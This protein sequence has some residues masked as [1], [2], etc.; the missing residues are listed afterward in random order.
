MEKLV[1][2]CNWVCVALIS[3]SIVLLASLLLGYHYAGWEPMALI[4]FTVVYSIA[5]I[6][7]SIADIVLVIINRIFFEG[8]EDVK[9]DCD[10]LSV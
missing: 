6:V 2:I 8:R 9:Y 1:N 10:C 3:S 7:I 5:A 4:N